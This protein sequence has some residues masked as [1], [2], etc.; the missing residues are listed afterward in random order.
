LPPQLLLKLLEWKATAAAAA[1]IMT[2]SG[3]K[4]RRGRRLQLQ[5][6]VT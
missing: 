1:T 5:Q 2:T 3:K 4:R 6:E